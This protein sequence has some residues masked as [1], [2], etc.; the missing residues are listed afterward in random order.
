MVENSID[1]GR[2]KYVHRA[3]VTPQLV[4]LEVAGCRTPLLGA[5]GPDRAGSHHLGAHA[6][7][8]VSRDA[9]RRD[10]AV[11]ADAGIGAT[12][13]S[14]SLT[15]R[16]PVRRRISWSALGRADRVS[17]GRRSST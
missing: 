13:L 5:A 16:S 3:W 15:A 7:A 12:D 1:T 2:F 8:R 10:A 6:L 11:P 17:K 14:R 9:S 4:S